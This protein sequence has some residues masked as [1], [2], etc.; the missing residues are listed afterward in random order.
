MLPE[1]IEDRDLCALVFKRL[2][3]QDELAK[4][5]STIWVFLVKDKR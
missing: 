3:L 5:V 4:K 2:T 1:N